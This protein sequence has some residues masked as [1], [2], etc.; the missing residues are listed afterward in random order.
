MDKQFRFENTTRTELVIIICGCDI[1]N[2]PKLEKKL[3]G[4]ILSSLYELN[5]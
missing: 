2:N 5:I 4:C 3:Q 1:Q